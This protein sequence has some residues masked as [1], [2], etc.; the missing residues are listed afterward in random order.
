ME[1]P[2]AQERRMQQQEVAA[3]A[4]GGSVRRRGKLMEDMVAG[5]AQ[6]WVT[7]GSVQVAKEER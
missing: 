2:Q 3:S 6:D 5:K 4:A 1:K 7:A